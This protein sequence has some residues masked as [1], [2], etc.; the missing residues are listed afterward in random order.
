MRYNESMKVAIIGAGELGTA[1]ARVLGGKADVALWDVDAA[2]VSGMKPL[3]ET[4]ALAE[5]IFCCVPS[6]AMR[7]AVVAFAPH[8]DIQKTI[9]ISLAKGIEAPT[10]K[11]MDKVLAE[12]L[13]GGRSGVMGGPMLAAELGGG[14]ECIG[15]VGFSNVANARESADT[16]TELFAG[17]NLDIEISDDPH[18][19]AI[20][21]VLK[22][23]YAVLMGIAFGRKT[24]EDE[25]AWLAERAMGEMVAIGTHLGAHEATMTGTAG[26]ADFLATAY[27]V[28]SRNRAVGVALAIDGGPTI[29]GEGILSLPSIIDLLGS[30]SARFS[31]LSALEGIVIKNQ[32]S[33]EVFKNIF[34]R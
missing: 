9:V 23:I 25:T 22:N 16:I 19:I 3:A 26:F 21:G 1:F 33:S 15:A 10:K 6:F 18:G 17:T 11:F 24:S 5:I 14:E 8:V 32:K 2:K 31:L 29:K 7:A 20:A 30:D 12:L 27:S 4:V 13:P 34:A 28:H